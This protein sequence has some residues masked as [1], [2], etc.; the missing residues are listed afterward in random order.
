MDV[1]NCGHL[2]GIAAGSNG[3]DEDNRKAIGKLKNRCEGDPP[4]ESGLAKEQQLRKRTRDAGEVIPPCTECGKNFWSRKALYGH[5]RL[6][7]ERAWRGINRPEDGHG[8]HVLKKEKDV[9][10]SLGRLSGDEDGSSSYQC[11]SCKRVFSSRQALGGHRATHKNV[12]GC[13]ALER[14]GGEGEG[15]N[16]GS[17]AVVER[18]EEQEKKPVLDLDLNFP[19]PEEDDGSRLLFLVQN[20]FQG[21]IA[22]PFGMLFI[23]P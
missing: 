18:V 23:R 15:G 22:R 21:T 2:A 14:D 9:A 10:A 17:G 4:L 8:G 20:C 16:G 7:P 11:S 3:D 12:K 5:M 1:L 13:Y 19:A 6:H